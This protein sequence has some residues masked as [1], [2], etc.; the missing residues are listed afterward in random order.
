VNENAED[1]SANP[2]P[3][4]LNGSCLQTFSLHH[5][6]EMR[7]SFWPSSGVSVMESQCSNLDTSLM[8]LCLHFE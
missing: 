4:D 2:L 3:A 5:I 1:S 8:P 7:P 6:S